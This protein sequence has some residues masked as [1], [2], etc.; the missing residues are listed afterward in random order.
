MVCGSCGKDNSDGN[1]FCTGCGDKLSSSEEF[2]MKDEDMESDPEPSTLA[3]LTI[4]VKNLERDLSRMRGI[5][6]KGSYGVSATRDLQPTALRRSSDKTDDEIVLSPSEKE[7]GYGSLGNKIP[8]LNLRL[9]FLTFERLVGLN[10]LAIV[11]ALALVVGIG[12]FLK[13]AFDNDWIGVTGRIALGLSVAIIMLGLGDYCHGKLLGWARAVTGGGIAILYLSVYATFGFFT[14]IDPIPALLFLSLIVALTG[15]LSL[16]YESR[17]IAVLGM[18]GAFI[19]PVLL[20]GDLDP[21]QRFILLIYVVV[22]DLGILAISILR[23]WRWFT[24]IGLV[25]SYC[26]FAI[27][28]DQVPDSEILL[29]LTGLTAIL[30]IFVGATTIFHIKW[31]KIPGSLDLALMT[32]NVAAY[33]VISINL[34]WD[35]YESWLGLFTILLASFYALIAFSATIRSGVSHTIPLYALG[36]AI[37]FLTLAV[38]IQLSG[39]WITMAWA[40]Q[41]AILIWLSL[42]TD[43][44]VLRIFSLGVFVA[45][46]ARLVIFDTFVETD[47]YRPFFNERVLTFLISIVAIYL[48]A[49]LLK[50]EHRK[51]AV[52]ELHLSS[53]FYGVGNFFTL[54]G[55]SAEIISYF[56]N[57]ESVT[58]TPS[59]SVNRDLGFV[60]LTPLWALYS[61]IV[62]SVSIFR[63]SRVLRLLGVIAAIVTVLKLVTLDT[64][65]FGDVQET[66]ILFLNVHFLAALMVVFALAISAYKYLRLGIE[67]MPIEKYVFRILISLAAFTGIWAL[68]TEI[69]RYFNYQELTSAKS[70]SDIENAKQLA[71][72]VLWTMYAIGIV[73]IGIIRRTSRLRLIGLVVLLI[74]VLKLFIFDVFQLEQEYRVVAFIALGGLLL[75][76]GL[77]YQWKRKEIRE[78]LIGDVA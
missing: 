56:D 12:F 71:L 21:S 57:K 60:L 24:L 20:N 30:F 46:A 38:P 69:I 63:D 64:F 6:E 65:V 39:S 44:P 5:L 17:T 49:Y 41:G 13:L 51:L 10:W 26:L 59:V 43:R 11:G 50:R 4:R 14:L 19:T 66:F 40:I 72:T 3:D 45:V 67:L 54:W 68:S 22:V 77:A 75:L 29:A 58:A 37:L 1:Q 76:T 35:D 48:A 2:L 74:P 23:N 36:T 33:Y 9:N 8:L 53:L 18:V 47:V 32:L 27:W 52:W 42:V 31:K 62:I 25:A 78:F 28:M 55:L 73:I 7:D 61:F 16:R 34:L 15:V 70:V